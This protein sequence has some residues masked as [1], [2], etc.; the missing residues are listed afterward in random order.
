MSLWYESHCH[1]PLCRHAVGE[2]E[3]YAAA[4]LQAGFAGINITDHGPTPHEW[5]HCM[6]RDQWP[7]YLRIVDRARQTYSGQ[8]DVKTGIE[9]DYLPGPEDYWR[10]FLRDNT[11]SHVLGSVH[12]QMQIFRDRYWHGDAFEF[13]KT[14]FDLLARAAETGL[15]DTLAHPDLVK[16]STPFD[17]N[18]ERIFPHI[19]RALDRIAAAGTAME[20]NTSGLQKAI[21]EM[22]PA[23]EILQ[24]ISQRQIPIVVGADAHVPE[25]VGADFQP[26]LSLLQDCGFSKVSYFIDRKRLSVAIAELQH[27]GISR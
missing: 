10:P 26:A 27:A 16:N 18:L 11:L 5:S 1:T 23:P 14:Y 17:W 24:A 3:A 8:L 6:R 25:R 15:F 13:Q 2:P 21:P 4:A 9:C 19:E 22:N 7:E 12:P 20:L